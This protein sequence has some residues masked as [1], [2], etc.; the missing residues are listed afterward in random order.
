MTDVSGSED[1][2]GKLK[3]WHWLDK[4]CAF[5]DYHIDLKS[6]SDIP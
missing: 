3:C 2:G 6:F 1:P 5:T 4:L